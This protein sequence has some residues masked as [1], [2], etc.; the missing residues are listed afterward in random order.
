MSPPSFA[1]T[2]RTTLVT[3]SPCLK[4]SVSF[5]KNM[6][7]MFGKR[8]CFLNSSSSSDN[9]KA[10][11]LLYHANLSLPET[12]SRESIELLVSMSAQTSSVAHNFIS[13]SF[14]SMC[15][16]LLLSATNFSGYSEVSK[17]SK[18]SSDS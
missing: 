3:P 5:F 18:M 7:F 15:A 16:H 2:S 12:T 1:K 10:K 17:L 4:P 6:P 11:N 8:A 14:Q 13:S 9:T